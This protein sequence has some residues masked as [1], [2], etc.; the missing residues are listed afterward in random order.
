[1]G[2]GNPTL[3]WFYKIHYAKFVASSDLFI[4]GEGVRRGRGARR[5]LEESIIIVIYIIAISFAILL[6]TILPF[7]FED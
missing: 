7:L 1:V 3:H 2:F 5:K 4:G 6:V